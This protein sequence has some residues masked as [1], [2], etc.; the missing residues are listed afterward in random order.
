[1]RSSDGETRDLVTSRPGAGWDFSLTRHPF[2]DHEKPLGPHYCVY[3]RRLMAVYF[4][5][6][7]VEDGYWTFRQAVGLQ[8]TGEYVLEF[9]GPDAERLLNHLFTRDVSKLKVDRCGYGLACFED[10]GLLVDG[11]LIRLASDRFWYVQADGDF[12]GWARAHAIG[13][14]V[15]ISDPD[16]FVS[17]VQGPNSLKFLDAVSATGLP[18]RF[19]YYG[20]ARVDLGGQTFVITRTGFTNELGWEIYTEP[21]HDADALWAH[22]KKHGDLFGLDMVPVDASNPRRIEA[23]ILNAGSDFNSFTTPCDVGLGHL[24]DE[25]KRDFLGKSALANASRQRRSFGVKCETGEMAISGPVRQGGKDVG[26]VTA[27]AISPFL[28]HSIGFALLNEA[29]LGPGAKVQVGCRDGSFRE[30]ELVEPPFYD[31]E[32]LIPRGRLVDVPERAD[33]L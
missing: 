9:K 17:Q 25:S 24:I 22:L 8:H 33:T 2:H 4:D 12:Y 7:S 29:G 3:N 21:H 26:V 19:A 6:R 1:M 18:D 23:G 5:H 16:V 13:M 27:A 14:D 20:V 32:R 11:I 15:E 10:G 31:K 28:R 30:A